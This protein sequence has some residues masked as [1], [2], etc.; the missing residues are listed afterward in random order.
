V[1]GTPLSVLEVV[2]AVRR[3]SGV[4]LTVCHGP[5]RPGEMPSVVVDNRR[6]REAGWVPRVGL[7]EGLVGV[8]EEWSRAE[9]PALAGER[10]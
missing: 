6:A 1:S 9:L 4:P 10:G 5:G 7:S 3:V 2:D 8:W